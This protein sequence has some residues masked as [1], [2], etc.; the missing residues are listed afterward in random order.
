MGQT[1]EEKIKEIAEKVD[2][3]QKDMAKA[4]RLLQKWDC[5]DSSRPWSDLEFYIPENVTHLIVYCQADGPPVAGPRVMSIFSVEDLVA[6][7][8][9]L[10]TLVENLISSGDVPLSIVLVPVRDWEYIKARSS[11]GDLIVEHLREEVAG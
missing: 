1:T 10:D 6:V 8:E 2:V 4:L 3:L 11:G 7:R 5:E 9:H